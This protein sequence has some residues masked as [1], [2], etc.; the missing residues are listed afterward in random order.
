M[1]SQVRCANTRSALATRS[2]RRER[3]T[4]YV[5][6]ASDPGRRI[7]FTTSPSA[8]VTTATHSTLALA[9]MLMV[10]DTK[11]PVT[12]GSPTRRRCAIPTD[13]RSGHWSFAALKMWIMRASACSRTVL[14]RRDSQTGQHVARTSHP[15]REFAILCQS[16]RR[17]GE[18]QHRLRAEQQSTP[19]LR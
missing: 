17:D 7:S 9:L 15:R 6:G 14:P 13:S 1:L 12:F 2:S 18:D 16:F 19:A 10:S 3:S 4:Q 8:F 5:G 11:I